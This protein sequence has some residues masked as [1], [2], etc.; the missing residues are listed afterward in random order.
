MRTCYSN[1]MY[2]LCVLNL[3]IVVQVYIPFLLYCERILKPYVVLKLGR[4]IRHL[5]CDNAA[6]VMCSTVGQGM[7]V[8]VM[9][10]LEEM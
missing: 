5:I 6:I 2:L 10:S 8:D 4:H 3:T 7:I 1:V 9:P